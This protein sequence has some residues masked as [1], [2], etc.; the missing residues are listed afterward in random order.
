MFHSLAG[1]TAIVTGGSRGIGRGIAEVFAAAGVNVIITGRN[2]EDL[3]RAVAASAGAAGAI[4]AVRADVADPEQAQ[5]VV[6]AA[7]ERH[8]GLDIV[9]ANAGIF[10]SGRLE[11][12]T[13]DDIDQVLAVNFKGTV[14]MVQAALGA[15]TTSGHGRVIVTSSIT[16]PV[17]GYPGWSHYGASKAAQ[18]GFL[19]TA[20]IELAPRKITINAVLPGNIT[21]E[22]LADMGGDYIDQ[23]TSAVPIGRLGSVADIGNAALFFATDEAAF[24]TGQSLVVD[25]GQI[26]PES[27]MAI[28]EMTAPAS[29]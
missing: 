7:I 2:Q 13:P 9:C 10:P 21:T 22:G 23:M 1:R 17:T 8:G 29:G 6:E 19:R 15:L 25:G 28:A 5:R 26:L 27:H 16:G 20:A 4:S 18:L 14:F 3:D 24:V 11:E 12:L